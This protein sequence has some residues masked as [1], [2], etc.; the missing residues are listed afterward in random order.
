MTGQQH[1]ADDEERWLKEIETYLAADAERAPNDAAALLSAL[2]EAALRPAGEFRARLLGDLQAGRATP[3]AAKWPAVAWQWL[4]LDGGFDMKKGLGVIIAVAIVVM[5][6]AAAVAPS[7]RADFMA[8]LRRIALGGSTDARQVEPLPGELPP[9]DYPWQ[10]PEGTYWLVQTDIGNFG[11]N[12]LP[13][14]SHEVQSVAGLDEAEALVGVCP[15]AP[16]E[17]P[18]GYALREVLVAPGHSR[19]FFQFYQGPGP[20]IV[21]VQTAVGV[22]LNGAASTGASASAS[23]AVVSLATDGLLEEVT[24]DNRPAAWIDDHLLMWEADGTTFQVGG[25]G[26]DLETAMAIGRSLQ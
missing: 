3:R 8:V 4:G 11:A 13:G 14:E 7:A 9:G 26:I 2:E 24:F 6:L 12:V 15:L 17:M 16:A 18:A 20:D 23:A 19:M 1:V 10:L 21:I 5:V 25:L 22:S